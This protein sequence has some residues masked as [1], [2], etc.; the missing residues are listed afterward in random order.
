MSARSDSSR[1]TYDAVI[2]TR[3]RAEALVLSIP[4]LIGQS[5]QPEQIIVIDS[6]DDPEPVAK[7]VEQATAGW[8]GTTICVHSDPGLPYQRNLGLR[9]VTAPVVLFP[10]DDSL[11]FPDAAERMLE[12][13]ESDTDE[14]V[15]GVCAAEADAPPPGVLEGAGYG[16]TGAHV[17]EARHRGLRNRL[18]KNLSFLKPQLFLGRTLTGRFGRPDW[19]TA[20]NAVIVEYMTGFRMSFRTDAIRRQ[21][22]D[23]ALGGYALDED[24]D[25]SFVAAQSGLL[26]GARDAKIYHHRFPSGRGN[27]ARLGRMEVLNRLYV[28]LKHATADAAPNGTARKMRWRLRGFVAAK[29]LVSLLGARSQFGRERLG[30]VLRAVLASGPIWRAAPKDLATA[31]RAAFDKAGAA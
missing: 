15:A 1:L 18:E 10:D 17:R 16:M 20:K 26:I 13:Y 31:Y 12:I 3:N 7:A 22:F 21:G 2:A 25:A 24:V 23:E 28:G 27:G 29:M 30:G 14:V 11:L 5:R 4:L 9:H 6:S 8:T 19:L